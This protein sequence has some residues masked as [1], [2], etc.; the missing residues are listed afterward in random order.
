MILTPSY[1]CAFF[2]S[3]KPS[4]QHGTR[5]RSTLPYSSRRARYQDCKGPPASP[6]FFA[7]IS[8]VFLSLIGAVAVVDEAIFGSASAVPAHGRNAQAMTVN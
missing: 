4:R 1:S 6:V 2:D 7:Y 3:R 8:P 5:C